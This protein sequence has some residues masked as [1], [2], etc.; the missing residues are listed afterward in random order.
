M[1]KRRVDRFTCMRMGADYSACIDGDAGNGYYRGGYNASSFNAPAQIAG[2]IL[3]LGK[4]VVQCTCIWLDE[5]LPLR[6][7]RSPTACGLVGRP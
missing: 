5:T 3:L 4:A 7:L 2:D 6:A 1:D